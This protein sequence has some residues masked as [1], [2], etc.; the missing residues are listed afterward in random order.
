M[1]YHDFL[2]AKQFQRKLEGFKPL[3]MPDYLKDFQSVLV[4][5]IIRMGSGALFE[6]CGLGKSIQS[7]VWAENILR[8]HPKDRVLLLTPLAVTRQFVQEADK[9]GIKAKIT[10]KGELHKGINITNY[11][12]LQYYRPEDFI[13]VITDEAGILKNFEGKIRQAI[14]RFVH[15][16]RYRLLCTATPA[17]NDYME[18]GSSSEA[19]GRMTRGQML[20]MFFVNGGETTQQWT[21]KGH[22]K[23]RFWQWV[24]TWARACRKPSDLGFDDGAYALPE[25]KVHQ[26]TLPSKRTGKGFRPYVARTLD[27]QRAERRDTVRERCLKVAT[28]IPK[29]RPV[30]IYCHLNNEGDLLKELISDAVQVAGSDRDE[31]KEERLLAFAN[32]Q[33]KRL[34]TKPKIAGFGLNLQVCSDVFYFPSYSWESYYQS[35]RRCWRFGQEREV[36]CHLVFSQAESHVVSA[37]LRKDRASEEMYAGIVRHINEASK[38]EQSNGSVPMEIP[39]WL[40]KYDNN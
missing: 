21:L 34:V 11:E 15:K 6:A 9:F 8:K 18:L 32:G 38:Q 25:L 26:H 23:S 16:V 20:S 12:R 7:L 35:I 19:L 31:D 28:L 29:D 10:R 27:D 4:D 17:P 40:S 39:R 14:T 37:M 22:A 2:K 13:A 36:N 3:F 24:A 1:D 30:L 5:W 33:I